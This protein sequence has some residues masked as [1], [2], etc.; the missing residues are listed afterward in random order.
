M[1]DLVCSFFFLI[2]MLGVCKNSWAE[3]GFASEKNLWSNLHRCSNKAFIYN[4]YLYIIYNIYK[5]HKLCGVMGGVVSVLGLY[6]ASGAQGS[7]LMR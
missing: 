3:V 2:Y 7:L 6:Q 5:R 1:F 4:I